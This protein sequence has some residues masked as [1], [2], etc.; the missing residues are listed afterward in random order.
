MDPRTDFQRRSSNQRL[1]RAVF[2]HD[3]AG[4]KEFLAP[5]F[6]E[7]SAGVLEH[8][9]LV[10]HDFRVRQGRADGG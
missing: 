2:A 1:P 6:I 8:V 9:K 10:E 4:A 3:G 7:S 5:D